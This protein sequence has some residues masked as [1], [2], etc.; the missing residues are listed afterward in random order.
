[1][2][3]PKKDAVAFETMFRAMMG[4]FVGDPVKATDAEPIGHLGRY[5]RG[6]YPRLQ[7]NVL[8]AVVKAGLLED[9]ARMIAKAIADS[10]ASTPTAT[11][12]VIAAVI[13]DLKRR[14]NE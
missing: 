11:E 8:S 13:A 1:M 7:R 2:L 5:L 9:V 3:D 14:L 12:A 10:E 6:G 4:K